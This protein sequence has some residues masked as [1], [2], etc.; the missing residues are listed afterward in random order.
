MPFLVRNISFG[1]HIK[2]NQFLTSYKVPVLTQ[3]NLFANFAEDVGA[4]EGLHYLGWGGGE[5]FAL[6]R[7]FLVGP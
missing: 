2:G 6:E 3:D 1:N 4:R 5:G 7:I